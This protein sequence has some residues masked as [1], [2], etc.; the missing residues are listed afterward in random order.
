MKQNG[1]LSLE[2]LESAI[3]VN[4]NTQ[5]RTTSFDSSG[6]EGQKIIGF[7][8]V[9]G[10]SGIDA[11]TET[12]Q[13]I[14]YSHHEIHGGSHYFLSNYTTLDLA[15]SVVFGVIVPDVTKWPHMLFD[16]QC[17]GETEFEIYETA[18]FTSGTTVTAINN[19]RNSANTSNLDIRQD[20]TV[21]SMGSL[22]AAQLV[23]VAQNPT[24]GVGGIARR[25]DE[26]IL[27]QNTKYIFQFTSGNDSNNISY[28][29]YWY[30]HTNKN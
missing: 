9:V 24:R 23:G 5:L 11:A 19:D 8:Y 13:T 25:D 16:F 17:T 4:S 22:I 30:E 28:R 7:D 6:N 20:P 26:I 27:K 3:S 18:S 10:N 2:E 21:V 15:S 29:A 1:G 14:D 12:Q